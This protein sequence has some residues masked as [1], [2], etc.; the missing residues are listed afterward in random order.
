MPFASLPSKPDAPVAY[1]LLPS[2]QTKAPTIV[3]I[4]GLGLPAVSWTKTISLFQESLSPQPTYLTYDRYGQGATASRD[5]LDAQA[6]D[7][8]YGHDINASV[9]DLHELIETVLPEN[10]THLIFVRYILHASKSCIS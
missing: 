10:S 9:T 7:P 6:P 5:P 2:S 1:Q 4:N 3:F 8:T